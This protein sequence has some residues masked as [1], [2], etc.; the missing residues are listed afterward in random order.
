[1]LAA[2]LIWVFPLITSSLAGPMNPEILPVTNGIDGTPN[3]KYAAV[4]INLNKVCPGLPGRGRRDVTDRKQIVPSQEFCEC[5]AHLMKCDAIRHDKDEFDNCADSLKEHG[6]G[7]EMPKQGSWSGRLYKHE[8][9]TV[10]DWMTCDLL[11]E[12]DAFG[13]CSGWAFGA[14]NDENPNKKTCYLMAENGER[15]PAQRNMVSGHPV[16]QY[17]PSSSSNTEWIWKSHIQ[18]GA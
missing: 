16:R 11:C 1:M 7:C 4:E 14:K 8:H 18:T 12:M 5:L 15:L 2:Q 13:K 6:T 10:K 3:D 17:Y 9:I